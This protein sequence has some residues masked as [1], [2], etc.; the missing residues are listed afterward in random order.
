MT[1]LPSEI[2]QLPD[3]QGYLTFASQAKWTKVTLQAGR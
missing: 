1:V 2:E 3:L